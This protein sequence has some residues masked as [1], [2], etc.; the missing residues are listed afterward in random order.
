MEFSALFSGHA[1]LQRDQPLPIWGWTAPFCRVRIDFGPGLAQA[2]GFS[3]DNGKFMIVLPPQAA[4][5][6]YILTADDDNGN[7]IAAEDLYV[8][9]VW[10]ASGQSNMD[11]QLSGFD[12]RGTHAGPFDFRA[13]VRTLIV[14]HPYLAALA[15]VQRLQ[16]G[17]TLPEGKDLLDWSAT[18]TYFAERVSQEL[19]IPVGMVSA[20]WGG[21]IAASWTSRETLLRNPD[22]ATAVRQYEQ[23]V[24]QPEQWRTFHQSGNPQK[25][26]NWADPATD[27]TDWPE[28]TVPGYWQDTPN[29][30]FSGI[31]WFRRRVALPPSWK[32]R[33]LEVS[34]GGA[35]KQDITYGNGVKIGATGKNYEINCWNRLRHYRLPATLTQS[36]ELLLAV[37]VCSFFYG[38]GL[39]GPAEEM[40]LTPVDAPEEKI[41]L[42]GSW[43]YQVE[44]NFGYGP[45]PA[46]VAAAA[47]NSYHML[48]DAM[49]HPLLPMAL[50]GVIWYQ[51]ESD[52][53]DALHYQRRMT[54]LITDWRWHFGQPEL[55]FIQVLLAAYRRDENSSWPL[56]RAA[57]IAAADATG[58]GYA[59]AMDTGDETNLHPPDKRPVGT[60]LALRALADVYGLPLAARGPK[61]RTFAV[62]H[63]R[64]VISFDYA[65]GLHAV[66]GEPDGF[67]L[68]GP[69]GIFYPATATIA[70]NTVKVSAPEVTQPETVRYAWRENPAAA[71]LYNAAGLPMDPFRARCG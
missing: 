1:V 69:N 20:T 11:M 71:N 28:M 21:T 19:K 56:L 43:R 6:P 61:P 2:A 34:L 23:T 14:Q 12:R 17:W 45:Q 67:E 27:D 29:L 65:D 38:G 5:G 55:P 62:C 46:D 15:K 41:S 18:A 13:P 36:G 49:I 7:R 53:N 44:A 24:A 37:R 26:R 8:G 31:L 51:G 66:T 39:I 68:A 60:R 30:N 57:Q 4:G 48:F 54:D 32:G 3:D 52:E 63:D 22:L 10:L 59:N 9:E 40:Y 25:A 42:A 35:D 70:G 64:A 47:A 58:T 50:R 33:E 16:T